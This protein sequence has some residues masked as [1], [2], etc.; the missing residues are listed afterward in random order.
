MIS[1]SIIPGAGGSNNSQG[2]TSPGPSFS[3]PTE[4]SK[5]KNTQVPRKPKRDDRDFKSSKSLRGIIQVLEENK[6]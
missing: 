6:T 4:S 2:T 3:K 5:G 1:I